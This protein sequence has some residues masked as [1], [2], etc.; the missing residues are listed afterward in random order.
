MSG[1]HFNDNGYCYYKVAQFLDELQ[2]EIE[3]NSEE[4]ERGYCPDLSEEIV[5]ELKKWVPRIQQ[6]AEV[7]RC[8]DYLYSGDYGEESFLEKIRSLRELNYT[9]LSKV[10]EYGKE[11]GLPGITLDQLISSHRYLRERNKLSSEEYQKEMKAG[12]DYGI[13]IAEQRMTEDTIKRE[14]LGKMTLQEIANFI[15]T[16]DE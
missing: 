13:K 12:Y 4:G 15:G 9:G 10:D 3:N 14:D 7:M 6:I 5:K 16:D 2:F 8:I 11:F 1:G